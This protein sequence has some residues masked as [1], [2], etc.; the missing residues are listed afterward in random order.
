M[1][2]LRLCLIF[3]LIAGMAVCGFL[4]WCNHEL[5]T[6][7][8]H[9]LQNQALEVSRGARLEQV[10]DVL[11]AKGIIHQTLP[12][13]LYMKLK[14]K[15]PIVQAGAYFFSSPITPL[16][17]LDKLKSGAQ[18]DR[19]TVIEGWNRWD[20]AV[21]LNR[22]LAVEPRGR[23]LAMEALNNP[24][25][26]ADIDPSATSLEGYLFPDTYFIVPNAT[27]NEVV[28]DMVKHFRDVW[29]TKLAR[30]AATRGLSAHQAV[31]IASIIETEAKLKSERPIIAS[32]IENRLKLKMP[33]SMD[34]TIVYASKMAGAWKNDG[35]V[36]QSDIDRVSPYNTRKNAGL[37]PGPVSSPGLSS[38]EAAIAP[39]STSYLY[40]VRNPDR[41]DGAHN[42]YADAKGFETGVAA[43]RAWEQKQKP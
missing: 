35:K 15:E 33:L 40:Y 11:Q 42:F 4:A 32:V 10:L 3:V 21:A 17:V 7:V 30:Q 13:R 43:L 25:A 1:N 28:S 8:N 18:F 31:T 39:A 14:H 22:A 19:I 20:I 29:L 5:H 16:Q 41:N 27:M 36:Y 12:L 23:D 37:P 26:V 9:E 24:A 6:A 2:A 34:S 38:L